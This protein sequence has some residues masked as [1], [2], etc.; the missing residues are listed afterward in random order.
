MDTH[1]LERNLDKL[2]VRARAVPLELRDALFEYWVVVSSAQLPLPLSLE[3]EP[4]LRRWL[5]RRLELLWMGMD[6]PWESPVLDDLVR[7]R[8][9]LEQ[10]PEAQGRPELAGVRRRLDA[11]A[12]VVAA[13]RR[14]GHGPRL[15]PQWQLL[16]GGGETSAPR[17]A[18]H[19]VSAGR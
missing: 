7:M 3:D 10:L 17:G 6:S 1:A 4:A 2:L 18:L 8:H 13:S 9:R 16:H 5:S 11:L 19:L 12:L 15:P 14:L